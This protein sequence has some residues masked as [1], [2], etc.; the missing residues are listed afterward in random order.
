M[1]K[2]AL[3]LLINFAAV[4][5][6]V[7]AY[8]AWQ[9]GPRVLLYGTSWQ[10]RAVEVSE[11]RGASIP[12]S[13]QSHDKRVDLKGTGIPGKSS[14]TKY[15]P[16]EKKQTHSP[17][18]STTYDVGINEHG[19][20]GESFEIAK[21]EGT[22]RVLTLGASSTF[23]YHSRDEETYPFQLER[24]LEA[25]SGEVGR[26]EVI[27][28]AIPHSTTDHVLAMLWNEGFRLDPD[29]ITFYEGANDAAVIE[30]REDDLL[31]G[32]GQVAVDHSLALALLDRFVPFSRDV[33]LE[34]WWSDG[35]AA[36]RER[37]F[38]GNLDRIREECERRGI[39]FI[40]ATQQFRS[41]LVKSDELKNLTYEEEVQFVR[42]K[43]RAGALGP[44]VKEKEKGFFEAAF[45][46]R[47]EE[48]DAEALAFL[49][50]YD[51][52]RAMLV[53][54]RL[55]DGLRAWAKSHG[56]PLVDVIE[57]LDFQRH[58]L[59]NWVHLQ[60]EANAIIADVLADEILR[61]LKSQGTP[62]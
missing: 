9:L 7:R 57:T 39:V 30:A 60:P 49:N 56:V 43:L 22:L 5:A 54:A 13:V 47:M 29:V 44:A 62:L 51:F 25:A 3:L 8:F 52:P 40:V 59:V 16:N 2:V 55:M 33:D 36:R 23:G 21:P 20:R 41:T 6:A 19:F 50:G 12:W 38:L 17:D 48:G 61:Q 37:A 32:V 27:N 42:E 58:L 1:L 26:F 24:A 28:F 11:D 46:L 34:W 14:Y 35:L 53:H 15:Y 31:Q 4:E 45:E 10:R 18:R